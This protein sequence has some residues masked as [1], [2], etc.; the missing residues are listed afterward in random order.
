VELRARPVEILLVDDNLGDARTLAECLRAVTFPYYLSIVTDSEAAL[1]FLERQAPYTEAPTPG[2]ILL[3]IHPLKH[4]GRAVLAWLRATPSLASIPV[5]MWSGMPVPV[6]E[7]QR[8]TLP[9]TRGRL[10]STLHAE[11]QRLAALIEK[12][13][14]QRNPDG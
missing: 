10:K 11:Y 1:A 9:P 5:V 2:L 4:S 3:D 7:E 14:S 12:I 8:D 13:L 6:D